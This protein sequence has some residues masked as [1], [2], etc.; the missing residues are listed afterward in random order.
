MC[1]NMPSNLGSPI[2][3]VFTFDIA[4]PRQPDDPL[5]S[6]KD[7][8][9]LTVFFASRSNGDLNVLAERKMNYPAASCGVS[10]KTELL[11]MYPRVLETLSFDVLLNALFI[12]MLPHV[13]TKYPSLQNSPPHSLLFTSGHCRNI[14][15]AVMLLMICTSRLGLYIGTDCTKKCT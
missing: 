7:N 11:P 1:G 12:A 5:N 10:E 15:R 8:R 3:R 13:L 9:Y 6:S 4:N 14:S 2:G